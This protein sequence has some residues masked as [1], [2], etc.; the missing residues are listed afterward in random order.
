M[1]TAV[2]FQST[3]DVLPVNQIDCSTSY[4]VIPRYACLSDVLGLQS[5]ALIWDCLVIVSWYHPAVHHLIR[6]LDYLLQAMCQ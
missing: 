1:L 6:S 5:L 4:G 3:S 2:L